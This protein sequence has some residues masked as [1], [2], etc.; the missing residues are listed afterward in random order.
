MIWVM[1]ITHKRY[2]V[3]F[4]AGVIIC[5]SAPTSDQ[6][7]LILI[8]PMFDQSMHVKDV[9]I[10]WFIVCRLWQIQRTMELAPADSSLLYLLI[11]LGTTLLFYYLLNRSSDRYP[12]GPLGLP[13]L[14]N[15]HQ[16]LLSGSIIKFCEKNS[17][18]FGNVSLQICVTLLSISIS[19]KLVITFGPINSW[20]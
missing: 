13:I 10:Q 19:L 5:L 4:S 2:C 6:L 12:P 18:R 14:G 9:W 7:Y 8:Q 17:K 15:V 20:S 11:V 3:L 16:I 1:R